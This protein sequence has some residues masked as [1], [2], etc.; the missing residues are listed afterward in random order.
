LPPGDAVCVGLSG[1][2][3]SVV[4]LDAL[5]EEGAR[6]VTAVHVHHGLSPNADAWAHF[7]G[8]L[9][10]ARKVA[11]SVERIEVDRRSAEGVEGAA[12]RLRH[13]VYAARPE[14]FVALAHHLDDQAETVLLQLLRGSGLKGVAAMPEMRA[15]PGS[16]TRLY[17][18][19]LALSRAQLVARA[20]ARG[21][22]WIED[23]SNDSTRYD[24]NYLRHDLAPLLDARFPGWRE[25]VARF[26]RHAGS[27]HELLEEL[28]HKD[29]ALDAGLLI[30]PALSDARRAN[31][32]RTFL[33]L[34]GLPMPSEARLEE[35][36]RQLYGARGDARVAIGHAGIVIR[37]QRD[38]V[39]I[40]AEPRAVPWRVPWRGE[41]EVDLG[42]GRG[43]VHFEHVKGRGLAASLA[44]G[45]GW[46]FMPRAGG[47]RIKLDARRPTRT[48][49][50]L[51]QE[52]DVPEWQRDRLP[53]LFRGEAL[54]WVPG[55]GIAAEFACEAGKDGI[56]PCWTVAGRA[57]L[58]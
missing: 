47:E 22:E 24:R 9:C 30:D 58:C 35:M 1:G 2:V 17:R 10:A 38:T 44:G 7:C 50:N 8:E 3:D 31:A 19:L 37:R 34:N 52:H 28:A 46:H 23:E 48:L 6:P 11:L 41:D 49:K 54:A 36:A 16:K 43:L 26:A 40:D 39:H 29:G 12:R 27:A 20:K 53:L 42:P 21:L 15:L 13:A 56:L 51:L 5:L 14:P 33:A 18:P 25:S 55:V 57:P 4:L 45:T 32:L